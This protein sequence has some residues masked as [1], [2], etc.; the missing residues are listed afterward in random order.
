MVR[1]HAVSHLGAEATTARQLPVVVASRLPPEALHAPADALPA[2]LHHAR[3]AQAP[4]EAGQRTAAG[5]FL[6]ISRAFDSV[7]HE[8]C[9]LQPSSAARRMSCAPSNRP[10]ARLAFM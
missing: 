2:S 4:G 5:R 6:D 10:S 9:T 7:P 8:M 3:T 1:D